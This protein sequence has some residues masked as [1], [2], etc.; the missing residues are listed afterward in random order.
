M[1]CKLD[2]HTLQGRSDPLGSLQIFTGRNRHTA[3]M[4]MGKYDRGSIDTQCRF[5]DFPGGDTSR[6]YAAFPYFLAAEH[7]TFCVQT[8]KEYCFH[9]SAEKE[10]QQIPGTLVQCGKDCHPGTAVNLVI[11]S[12]IRDKVQE[13]CGIVTDTGHFCQFLHAGFQYLGKTS[14]VVQQIMGNGVGILPG[15]A[16]VQQQFQYLYIR[17]MVQAFLQEAVFHPLPMSFM[18]RI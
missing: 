2:I 18:N 10:W 9:P 4:V 15:N 14:E 16:V 11:P 7:L 13:G 12:H 3:G 5:H 1:V 17:K 8:Q 6:I